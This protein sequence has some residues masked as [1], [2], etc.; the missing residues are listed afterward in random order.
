MEFWNGTMTLC[1]DCP[2]VAVRAEM[3]WK[4]CFADTLRSYPNRHAGFGNAP[5]H[6][7]FITALRD[8]SEM[9]V[10]EEGATLDA[11]ARYQP[12]VH[13]AGPVVGS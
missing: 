5:G 1:S 10:A 7:D 13:M 8:G 9:I 11:E 12:R 4:Y 6:Y 2:C 3:Q